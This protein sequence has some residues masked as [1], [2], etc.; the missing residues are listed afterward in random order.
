MLLIEM[1]IFGL[2]PGN[3]LAASGPRVEAPGQLNVF[4]DAVTNGKIA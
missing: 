2:K 4:N 3:H 1:K